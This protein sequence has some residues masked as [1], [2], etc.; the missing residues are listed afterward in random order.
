MKFRIDIPSEWI[1]NMMISFIESGDPVTCAAKGGWC[2]SV[3]NKSRKKFTG[4]WWYADPKYFN[5]SF[6]FEVI[7]LDDETTGHETRH[8]VSSADVARGMAVMVKKFPH[9]FGQVMTEDT[10]APCAD[11]FMQCCLFGEEKYA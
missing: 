4:D 11:I 1:A 2:V 7:E 5:G 9:Q 8:V 3:A 6:K 10:D